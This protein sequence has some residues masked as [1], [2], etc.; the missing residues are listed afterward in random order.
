[1]KIKVIPCIHHTDRNENS[2]HEHF[3]RGQHICM[4]HSDFMRLQ[5]S[6]A[7]LS[8]TLAIAVKSRTNIHTFLPGNSALKN[9][10]WVDSKNTLEDAG[11][12]GLVCSS[13]KACRWQAGGSCASSQR[14]L[15]SFFYLLSPVFSSRAQPVACAS[16]ASLSAEATE[17]E[18]VNAS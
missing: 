14:Y 10:S 6:T 9:V 13:Q 5:T 18:Q 16:G 2:V 3:R 17:E 7:Y 4:I 11:V 8:D 15:S 1:M 12:R